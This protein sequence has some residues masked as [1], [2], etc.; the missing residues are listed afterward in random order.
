MRTLGATNVELTGELPR[1]A[2]G[3]LLRSAHLGISTNTGD[4]D[5]PTFP[6]KVGVYCRYGRA[7]VIA[8]EEASDVGEFLTERGAGVSVPA[9][10]T[11]RSG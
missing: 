5:V 1:A 9:S 4:I 6:T 8:A 7:M 10:R 3:E 11:I 2:Y